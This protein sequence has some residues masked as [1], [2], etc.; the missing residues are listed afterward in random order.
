MN[1][2]KARVYEPVLALRIGVELVFDHVDHDLIAD[3]T[4][5]VH[6]LLGLLSELSLLGDLGPQHIT[7]SL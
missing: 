7:S 5:L 2:N 1:F 4:T 6:D 3:K